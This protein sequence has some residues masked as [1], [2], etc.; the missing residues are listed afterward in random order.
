MSPYAV[1]EN[2]RANIQ[3][4]V[5]LT[6]VQLRHAQQAKGRARSGYYKSAFMIGASIVEALVHTL[7]LREIGEDG[8]VKTGAKEIY[9]CSPLPRS[10]YRSPDE[11]L[12]IAKRRDEIISIRRNTDFVVLNRAC[13]AKGLF[14]K[15]FFDAVEAIRTTRNKIHIQGLQYVDRSYTQHDV[16]KTGRIMNEL[17]G[18]L[19]F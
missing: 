15:K 10:F 13:F 3:W 8:T 19:N 2:L 14:T 12:V 11:G 9:E 5:G 1:N 4:N 17:L 16:E 18:R 6:I 7:L